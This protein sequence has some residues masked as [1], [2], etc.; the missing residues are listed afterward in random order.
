MFIQNTDFVRDQRLRQNSH[1][2]F[3][4]KRKKRVRTRLCTRRSLKRRRKKRKSRNDGNQSDDSLPDLIDISEG[5]TSD[6]TTDESDNSGDDDSSDDDDNS[7]DDDTDCVGEDEKAGSNL[8]HD[9][10]FIMSALC[11][12]E[13]SI[14]I[15]FLVSTDNNVLGYFFLNFLIIC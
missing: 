12:I 15:D 4:R 8:K 7:D 11:L 1:V 14:T 5:E 6:S 3:V 9:T 13:K 2:A 10:S